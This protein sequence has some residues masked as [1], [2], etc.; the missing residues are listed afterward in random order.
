MVNPLAERSRAFLQKEAIH[1]QWQSDYLNSDMD[2][3][4]DLAFADIIKRI[5]A[6]PGD[7]VLDAGCGYGYHTVRLARSGATI[8]AIDFSEPA[9]NEARSTIAEAEIQDRVNLEQA[10]LTVLP[11]SPESFNYIVCWG[12][13][14]HIPNLEAALAEL[15]R[16][17]KPQGYLVLCENNMHSPDIAIRERA[18]HLFNK[19]FRGSH[20]E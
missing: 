2:S 19:L 10:D 7:I 20:A 12:V 8:T 15:T 14:M 1:S 18:I 5:G 9:L 6:K 17:L 4:Y 11:F 3:F 13:L 16:V